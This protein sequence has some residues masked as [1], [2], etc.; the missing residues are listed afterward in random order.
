[1]RFPL[2]TVA[3]LARITFELVLLCPLE[4]D[5]KIPVVLL[6]AAIREFIKV[7]TFEVLRVM[8]V[9]L[10]GWYSILYLF[11]VAS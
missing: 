8:A 2:L 7:F 6:L 9:F 10:A 3:F 11:L 1:M 4:L 5:C